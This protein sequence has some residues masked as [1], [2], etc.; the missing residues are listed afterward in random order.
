MENPY[1]VKK[2][3]LSLC[4]TLCSSLGCGSI[5]RMVYLRIGRA[6]RIG[7]WQAMTVDLWGRNGSLR[8]LRNKF[9]AE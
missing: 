7:R 2:G 4:L 5:E 9:G 1:K 3:K 6:S 8:N